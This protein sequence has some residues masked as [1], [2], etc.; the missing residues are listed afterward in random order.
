MPLWPGD[1]WVFVEP[2]SRGRVV[3][4]VLNETVKLPIVI[5]YFRECVL[6]QGLA[7]VDRGGTGWGQDQKAAVLMCSS[8]CSLV[9]LYLASYESEGPE[10]HIEKD[11]WKSL[12]WVPLLFHAARISRCCCLKWRKPRAGLRFSKS[13]P[14]S[15]VNW[16]LWL[17]I[18]IATIQFYC[19]FSLFF[20]T[21]RYTVILFCCLFPVILWNEELKLPRGTLKRGPMHYL[22][23]RDKF[24]CNFWIVLILKLY[25]TWD[26]RDPSPAGS[27]NLNVT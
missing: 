24:R 27:V 11:R 5:W 1:P 2:V 6:L 8:F 15:P 12:R 22:H 23:L 18:L 19:F 10:N 7:Q 16:I 14:L 25:L 21:G 4:C 9:A 17:G 3:I 13:L 26:E 20:N